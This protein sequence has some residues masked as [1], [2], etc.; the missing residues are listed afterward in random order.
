MR[1][2]IPTAPY[3]AR[4]VRS[5]SGGSSGDDS[6][7]QK[8]DATGSRRFAKRSRGAP[9]TSRLHRD[10]PRPLAQQTR[11][12]TP[13]RDAVQPAATRRA[14]R[15]GSERA[16]RSVGKSYVSATP[17]RR[18]YRKTASPL[19]AAGEP[20]LPVRYPANVGPAIC[21]LDS[22]VHFRGNTGSKVVGAE[23]GGRTDGSLQ[24]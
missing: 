17:K 6:P 12:V 24:I 5:A 7:P 15:L 23:T 3:H 21:S 18:S 2:A 19:Q 20:R 10:A 8:K 9:S 1:A 4:V 11:L 13:R 16:R 14:T 22:G